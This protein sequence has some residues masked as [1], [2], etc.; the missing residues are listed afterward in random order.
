MGQRSFQFELYHSLWPTSILCCCI[1]REHW[2]YVHIIGEPSFTEFAAG[3]NLKTVTTIADI[4]QLQA[5]LPL[6]KP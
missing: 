2:V 4:S 1:S 5:T 6:G 3:E